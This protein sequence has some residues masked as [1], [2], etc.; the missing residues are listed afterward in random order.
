MKKK[1]Y[2]FLILMV[3]C[4]SCNRHKDEMVQIMDTATE[5]TQIAYIPINAMAYT[6]PTE[7]HSLYQ[8]NPKLQTMEI[9][10]QQLVIIHIC[11]NIMV[12]FYIMV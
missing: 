12:G 1:F 4:I 2:V 5:T 11:E 9:K 7:L 3:G 10:Q 8:N 6:S